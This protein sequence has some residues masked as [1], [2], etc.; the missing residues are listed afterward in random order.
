MLSKY[1]KASM[2]QGITPYRISL[3]KDEKKKLKEEEEER[4]RVEKEKKET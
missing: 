2:P 4:K 3:Y 1:A